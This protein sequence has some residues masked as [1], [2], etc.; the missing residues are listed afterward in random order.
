MKNRCILNG[1]VIVMRIHVVSTI[2]RITKKLTFMR[3]LHASHTLIRAFIVF[4]RPKTE[5]F[6]VVK[7]VKNCNSDRMETYISNV[8]LYAISFF[9]FFS[10]YTYM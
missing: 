3:E 2:G 10:H 1:R 5:K 7:Q 8:C 4:P 9:M 6:I